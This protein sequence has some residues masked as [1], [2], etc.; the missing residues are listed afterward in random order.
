MT[1]LPHPTTQML[2]PASGPEIVLDAGSRQPL[3][4]GRE[5]WRYR[6]LLRCLALRDVQVRY[7]QTLLGVAWVVIQPLVMTG[8]FTAFVGWWMG[9]NTQTGNVP[10]PV[11][12]LAGLLPWTFFNGAVS[13]STNSL[14]SNAHL[15]R[16][17]YFPR[18]L[19]P[20]AAM[21]A[22]LVD[23]G[24]AMV[25]LLAIVMFT[26]LLQ[27][28]GLLALPV[29]LLS[30]MLAAVSVGV[31]ISALTVRYRDFR[32]ISTFLLQAWFYLTPVF[33][34]VTII[35]EKF[36]SLLALNPATGPVEAMRAAVTGGAI[37]W[38][39]LGI[40]AASSVV[41]L[42]VGLWVFQRAQREIADLI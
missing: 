22:P 16:K 11:F 1:T 4:D 40:S 13:A 20:L 17:I 23:L 7:K 3:L 9:M 26:G 24:V 38:M 42:F 14:I 18:L 28:S 6:D 29:A 33:Y 19:L 39:S 30:L 37:N 15:I 25:M 5:L 27:F 35:P 31:A 34:P 12:V 32:Y 36:R 8:V 10:Y 41:F 2:E 21:G